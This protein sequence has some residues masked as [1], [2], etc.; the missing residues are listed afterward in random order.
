MCIQ[1]RTPGHRVWQLGRV[2]AILPLSI[3]GLLLWHGCL[4][5]ELVYFCH[6]ALVEIYLIILTQPSRMYHL[7]IGLGQNI[8]ENFKVERFL[9]V[10]CYF[11]HITLK[12]VKKYTNR[13]DVYLC[14]NDVCIW[15]GI[16]CNFIFD[17][18]SNVLLIPKASDILQNTQNVWSYSIV[19]YTLCV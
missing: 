17:Y 2:R 4:T 12:I 14:R 7:F 13:N 3:R 15:K 9:V 5:E 11:P 8:K 16:V 18:Y 10:H 1:Y 6:T 19:L